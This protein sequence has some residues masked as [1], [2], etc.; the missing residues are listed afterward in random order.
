MD[1]CILLV[2]FSGS[3]IFL[4]LTEGEI[5][6]LMCNKKQVIDRYIEEAQAALMVAEQDAR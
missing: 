4:S 2:I 5:Q 6:N 1:R 3:S